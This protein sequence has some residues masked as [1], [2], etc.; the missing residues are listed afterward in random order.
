MSTPK[1]EQEVVRAKVRQ[2]VVELG[3]SLREL[4]FTA[5]EVA[6]MTRRAEKDALEHANRRS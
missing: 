1:H 3:T 6:G 4:G 5:E 2:I